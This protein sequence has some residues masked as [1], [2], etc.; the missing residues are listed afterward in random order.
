MQGDPFPK[1]GNLGHGAVESDP[2]PDS[3]TAHQ[4]TQTYKV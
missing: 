4:R 1:I 2:L 3:T